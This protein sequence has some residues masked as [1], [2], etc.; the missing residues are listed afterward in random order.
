V[1]HARRFLPQK[2]EGHSAFE[3]R[4]KSAADAETSNRKTP[5]AAS[6]APTTPTA[7]SAA[8]ASSAASAAALA[9]LATAVTAPSV[10]GELYP[11][12]IFLIEHVK[13]PQ[14]DVREFFLL[15]NDS[16]MWH[17]VL[18]PD[19]PCRTAGCCGRGARQ[20]Q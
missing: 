2:A 16:V 14:T 4:K 7:A 20:R 13:G 6:T 12:L 18:S 5:A 8:S 1:H 17:G 10:L 3:W 19:V 11:C 15:K 9:A